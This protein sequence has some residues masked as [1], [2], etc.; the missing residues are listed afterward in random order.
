MCSFNSFI[1]FRA[2]PCFRPFCDLI[3]VAL[4]TNLPLFLMGTKAAIF[5]C[6]EESNVLNRTRC[7]NCVFRIA[8]FR[9]LFRDSKR[10]YIG[11]YNLHFVEKGITN[12]NIH[13]KLTFSPV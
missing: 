2:I 6:L 3:K 7:Q 12:I 5:V 8:E 4:F 1:L 10:Q 11:L 9:V 13:Q